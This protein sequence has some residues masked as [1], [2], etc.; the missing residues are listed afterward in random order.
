MDMSVRDMQRD[1]SVPISP[2]KPKPVSPISFPRRIRKNIGAFLEYLWELSG[3]IRLNKVEAVL[4][5]GV[6]KHSG[7]TLTCFYLGHY[8][9]YAFLL[10][11]LYSSYGVK[12]KYTRINSFRARKWINRYKDKVDL[13]FI[14]L[15]LLYCKILSD[16]NFLEVPQWVRQSFDV[17]DTWE[18]VLAQFRKN[19][20]KTDL[21][22]V[23]KYGFTYRITKDEENYKIFYH[24]M[25]KPYLEKRF[26]DAVLIEPEWK[27]LRQCRK[28]ELMQIVRDDKVV[29]CVL[30]HLLNVRLAYVWVGVP[31]DLDPDLAN[32]A[33]SALYYFTILYGYEK[34]CREID[35]LGSRPLLNDGLFRYKRK[36]GMRVQDSPVPR[37]DILL[38]PRRLDGPVANLFSNNSFITRDGSGICGKILYNIQKLSLPH[39][40]DLLENQDTPGL[41]RL[42]IYAMKGIDDEARAWAI[43]HNSEVTLFD[44]SDSHAPQEVFCKT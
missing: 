36:W 28:G 2:K 4:I 8:D 23:R 26:G 20:K 40:Q 14:D 6:E 31:D 9:N 15:E 25:Y 5:E 17:P 44:L 21:R 12:E 35:F 39:L 1:Y 7:A 37:G 22:K 3:S 27:V 38:R 43:V 18:E 34:G 13:L 41:T 29:S 30:L 10:N 24:T 19:T 16:Y 32:G 11:H 42:K 33:F